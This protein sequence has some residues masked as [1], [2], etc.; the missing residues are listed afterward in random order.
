V[1]GI[2]QPV[3]RLPARPPGPLAVSIQDASFGFPGSDALALENLDLEIP[4]GALVAVTGPVGS[5]KSALARAL[6]GLYPLETG[7]VLLDG[8]R[9]DALSEAERA[10]HIGYLPQNPVLFSGTVRQNLWLN[11]TTNAEGKLDGP[12]PF[13]RLAALQEDVRALPNGLD[14]EIGERGVRLSGGQRQRIAL[15]RAVTAKPGVLVLD[16]PFSAVDVD[17]EAQI[18]AELHRA[19]GPAASPAQQATVIFFS[20]RLA[21]FPMADLV[22]VLDRGQIRQQGTHADLLR[23]GGLYARIYHAQQRVESQA[24]PLEPAP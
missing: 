17:T 6:L 21:A 16:D 3:P 24:V 5:G 10:A 22:V 23:A 9:L 7:R 1:P 14:T 12:E 13:I 19:F 11:R 15:A 20:H 18:I 8:R 2:R 4:P